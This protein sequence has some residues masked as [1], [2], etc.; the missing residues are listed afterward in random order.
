V[1]QIINNDC[2]L[3]L[4]GMESSIARLIIADPPYRIKSWDGFGSKSDKNY[5]NKEAPPEYDEWL[6]ECWRILKGDGS[7][8]VFECPQNVVDLGN[9]MLKAGFKL[10]PGLV[11][12]VTFRRSHPRKGWYNTHWEPIMWGTKSDKWYFNPEPVLGKGSSLGGDVYAHPAINK[13]IVPGQKPEGLIERL[14]LCHSEPSDLVVD[15]FAGS[16]VTMEM[17]RKNGRSCIGIEKNEATIKKAKR[18]RDIEKSRVEE[19]F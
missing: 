8:F 17:C 18:Y 2:R 19:V 3:A 12:F 16:F 10:Q 15:P 6:L 1:Y 11:W 4:L 9:A 5:G 7:I 14:I 13:A